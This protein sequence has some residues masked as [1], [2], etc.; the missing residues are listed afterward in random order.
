MKKIVV[1]GIISFLFGCS[2]SR[3]VSSRQVETKLLNQYTFLLTE[4]SK[5]KTYGLSEKNPIRVGGV[6][7]NEGPVNERRFLNALA[8][9]NG[10][11]ISRSEERRVGKECRSR[12]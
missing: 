9:P 6:D 10:E 3:S 4:I 7:K 5:D 2:A 11:K 1:L 12:W 8:G